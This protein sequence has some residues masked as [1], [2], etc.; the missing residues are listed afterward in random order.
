[1]KGDKIRIYKSRGSAQFRW[2]YYT[3]N[4]KKFA[5]A[6]ETFK[7]KDHLIKR[8]NQHFPGVAIDDRTLP[9]PKK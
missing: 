1:M 6:G 7:R 8:L 3:R 9:K 5:T 4:G 2:T